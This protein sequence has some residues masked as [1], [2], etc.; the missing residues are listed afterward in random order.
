M[1]KLEKLKFKESNESARVEDLF[2]A[3]T[4]MIRQKEKALREV[5]CRKVIIL[6]D[7]VSIAKD[8]RGESSGSLTTKGSKE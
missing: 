2:E 1:I 8:K 6:R 7:E 5:G 3:K 4:E